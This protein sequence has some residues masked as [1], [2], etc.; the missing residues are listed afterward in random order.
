MTPNPFQPTRSMNRENPAPFGKGQIGRR[1]LRIL[2]AVLLPLPFLVASELFVSDIFYMNRYDDPE[3]IRFLDNHSQHILILLLI[4]CIE[5][6]FIL[7]L[8][9]VLYSVVLEFL[10]DT[11]IARLFAGVV[12]GGLATS[13]L[14]YYHTIWIA[15]GS[16]WEITESCVH[17]L[18]PVAV[19]TGASLCMGGFTNWMESPRDATFH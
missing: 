8:P 15:S 17:C 6:A 14:L 18:L 7:G 9:L 5:T 11:T 2:C 16:A 12:F 13:I 1:L 3:Y 4:C 10:C 19:F